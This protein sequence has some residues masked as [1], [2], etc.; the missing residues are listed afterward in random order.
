M[1]RKITFTDVVDLSPTEHRCITVELLK[2]RVTVMLEDYCDVGHVSPNQAMGE[3]F[4]STMDDV[5]ALSALFATEQVQ[6][7]KVLVALL[8]KAYTQVDA[9]KGLVE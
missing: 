6:V 3:L 5:E 4:H 9:L 2:D 1:N 7:F 8:G